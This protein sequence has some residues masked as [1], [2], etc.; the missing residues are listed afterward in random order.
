MKQRE[1]T[2]FDLSIY[3]GDAEKSS[4]LTNR[5]WATYEFVF[6]RDAVPGIDAEYQLFC[7]ALLARAEKLAS[8]VVEGTGGTHGCVGF[9]RSVDSCG[10]MEKSPHAQKPSDGAPA[11]SNAN[12]WA[13][14][15]HPPDDLCNV[16]R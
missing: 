8:G 12:A 7:E 9:Q 4:T 16:N 10:N 2:R 1:G 15:R 11:K 13:T 3:L 6:R 5:V 14:R